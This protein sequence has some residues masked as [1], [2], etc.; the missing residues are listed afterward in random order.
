[1][2]TNKSL[3]ILIKPYIVNTMNTATYI[4]IGLAMLTVLG[5]MAIG[6][7]SMIKGGAF[8]EKYGNTL[9]RWRVILQGLTIALIVF[10][11]LNAQD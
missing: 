3:E 7:V 8:N 1:M 4:I 10:A 11:V 9:M 2:S 5:V 6:I